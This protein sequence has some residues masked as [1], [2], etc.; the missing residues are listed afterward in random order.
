MKRKLPWILAG[1]LV[2]VALLHLG[3][4]RERPGFDSLINWL[5]SWTGWTTAPDGPDAFVL[6]T[7]RTP[8]MLV[9][10]FGGAALAL[11]GTVMQASFRN[12]LAS[13]DIIGTAAGAAF[14]GALAIVF[15][16]ADWAVFV[17]PI[18]ALV[19]AVSVTTLVFVLAGSH[20]RFTVANLLLA[21]IAL[22]TLFGALT[23]FVVTFAFDNYTASSRVLF[24][25]MGGLDARTWQHAWITAGG[26]GLFA[27][28]VWPRARE[29]DLLTLR[30]DSAHS[31]GVDAPRARRYLVW[32][33][34]GL[35]ATTVANS[36]GIAFV[37]LIV[38]HL[39]RLLVGPAH[40]VLLPTAALLGA[41]LMVVSDLGCRVSP[42]SWNLRL[43]VVT[44]IAGAPYFLYLLARQ[45]RGVSL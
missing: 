5:L 3:F 17:T 28:M 33:A 44:A 20:G 39:A 25:L 22:N 40:R 2:V 16:W 10:A 34:C 15:G 9:A 12:P 7:I 41:V 14:G 8:R 19:G 37:G 38:P 21:G 13:P 26:F 35:T 31:L 1:T 6:A 11:A 30:D 23:S 42:A 43:G 27:L 24:W 32:C 45:R 18:A 4:A 36:G 29:L